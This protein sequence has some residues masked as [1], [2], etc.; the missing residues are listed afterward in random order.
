MEGSVES[1]LKKVSLLYDTFLNKFS[2]SIPAS[3][4]LSLPIAIDILKSDPNAFIRTG[5]SV[6]LFSNNNAF[7]PDLVTLS[8]ISVISRSGLINCLIRISSFFFSSSLI[9]FVNP[10]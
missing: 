7:P 1:F 8:V 2:I 4:R 3:S 5:K 9:K 10:E 6:P